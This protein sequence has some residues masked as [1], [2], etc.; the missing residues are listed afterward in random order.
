[1]KILFITTSHNGLS[2]RAYVELSELGHQINLQLATSDTAMEAAVRQYKPELIIAPFLKTAIPPSIWKKVPV[3]IVH[4]GIRGDRGPSSLDWA[5][6]EEWEEWGVTILQAAEEMDAGDIWASHNFKM[7]EVS[8]SSLYRHEVT[9]AAMLGLLEAV[10]KFESGTFTPEPL[11]YQNP[12]VKGRLHMP[13][14]TKDRDIDWNENT[15]SILRKIR[16]ADSAPG[17]L[18]EIAGEKVRLFGAHKEGALKGEPGAII[19]KRDGAICRATGDGAVWITHL[20]Q[21]PNGIKL[22]A[23]LVLGDKLK[24][25]PES[26]LSPFDDYRGLATFREIWYEE[27][28]KVGYLHFDFYNGAMSTDQ[29]WRLQQA[30]ILAKQKETKVIVL[31]GGADIWSNGIHLNV[32][33]HAASPAQESWDYIVAMDNLVREII[34]TD[35]HFVVSAMQGNA[36]AGGAILALAAD[37]IFARS[38]IMLNPHYKKMG[39]LYGS[40]Y[41]TYLL[42]KRVGSQKALE[43]TEKCLPMGTAQAKAI[44]FID[45]H[46]GQNVDSFCAEVRERAAEVASS[47]AISWLLSQK[48]KNRTVDEAIKTLDQYRKEELSCMRDNFFGNDPSYHIARFHF[49]HKISCSLQPDPEAIEKYTLNNATSRNG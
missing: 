1:M 45:E 35:T 14:K 18:D 33:E 13:V 11:D 15:D 34:D 4:P 46:F 21:H 29:C 26:C 42:P 41:W 44:G 5:I 27:C 20:R 9:Q 30:L 6:M 16:A 2:Q 49:V 32:I 17:V 8:K 25:V 39:G 48:R 7:R 31:M 10:A 28:G 12:A 24:K 40:E 37:L 23:A 22:P 43:I 47:P 3:L 38:G 19:V 36:G